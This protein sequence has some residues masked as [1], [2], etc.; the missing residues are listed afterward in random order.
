ML[1]KLLCGAAMM[2]C[3]MSAHAEVKVFDFSYQN[4]FQDY[5]DVT[6]I[7]K[8]QFSVE[9]K[10]GDGVYGASELIA[11]KFV[12]HSYAPCAN[13]SGDNETSC[14]INSFSYQ[15]GG[16]LNFSMDK[17]RRNDWSDT[18]YTAR[19]GDR[20][21]FTSWSSGG[22]QPYYTA[23]LWTENTQFSITAVP[24]PQTYMMLGA[25]LLALFGAARRRSASTA[26]L[27]S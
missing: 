16:L 27:E 17:T 18:Y 4:F 24:E 6:D 19:S 13:E 9:D 1:K 23:Y 15:P 21:G 14:S 3:A 7:L 22:G 10:N 2:A 8:G 5:R 20:Y 11:F 25:G 12:N 26:K